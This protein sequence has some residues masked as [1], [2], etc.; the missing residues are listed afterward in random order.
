MSENMTREAGYLSLPHA[1]IVTSCV[2]VTDRTDDL[3]V[4][5]VYLNDTSLQMH[6]RDAGQ[7]YAL[8]D[9]FIAAARLLDPEGGA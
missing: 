9:A 8:A 6:I 1:E 5:V 3:G 4:A 2:T 7:A